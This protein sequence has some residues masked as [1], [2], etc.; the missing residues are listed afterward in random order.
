MAHADHVAAR[1]SIKAAPLAAKGVARV[2]TVRHIDQP[3]DVAAC[4]RG[5]QGR[6]RQAQQR[7][8]LQNRLP[9]HG[10]GL[11]VMMLAALQRDA[12]AAA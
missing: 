4:R 6:C 10:Y 12:V 1:N 2:V 9:C 3:Q 7:Q 11:R 8:R 5:L